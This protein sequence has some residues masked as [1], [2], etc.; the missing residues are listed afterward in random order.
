MVSESTVG[1]W[2]VNSQLLI[3]LK[4]WE[5]SSNIYYIYRQRKGFWQ[6]LT[7]STIRDNVL[8]KKIFR[9]HHESNTTYI[10]RY[11]NNN[12]KWGGGKC[13]KILSINQVV[14]QVNSLLPLPY[15]DETIRRKQKEKYFHINCYGFYLLISWWPNC[16]F[17]CRREFSEIYP[18]IR[19]ITLPWVFRARWHNP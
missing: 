11:W 13:D 18:F 6:A 15:V 14:R 5:S 1:V 9:T 8:K 16:S 19:C 17:L 3:W 7:K 2:I 4:N 10:Y 12:W